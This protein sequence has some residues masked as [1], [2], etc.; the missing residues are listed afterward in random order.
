MSV[1]L[2]AYHV[3]GAHL[4]E[5]YIRHVVCGAASVLGGD[6]LAISLGD[7]MKWV[8]AHTCPGLAVT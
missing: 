1:N 4:G 5:L 6:N 7:L 2:E 3:A 8:Q